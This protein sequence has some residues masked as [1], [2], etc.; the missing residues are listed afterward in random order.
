MQRHACNYLFDFEP[1]VGRIAFLETEHSFEW[2]DEASKTMEEMRSRTDATLMP[3]AEEIAAR[4]AKD[5]SSAAPADTASIEPFLASCI[6]AH[7]P[8]AGVALRLRQTLD[9]G[10]PATNAF[11]KMYE[12]CSAVEEVKAV[13]SRHG[14]T[15]TPLKAAFLAELPALFPIAV[16]YYLGNFFPAFLQHNLFDYCGTSL[17]DGLTDQFSLVG[18]NGSKWH[19]MDHTS[20]SDTRKLIA[21]LGGG[22]FDFVTGDI[23]KEVVNLWTKEREMFR[24]ELGQMVAALALLKDGGLA[25]LKMFTVR[26]YSTACLLRL[27]IGL[28]DKV[29]IIKPF[30]SRI[31]NEETYWILSGFKKP[32]FDPMLEPL[33][34]LMDTAT[35]VLS[36]VTLPGSGGRTPIPF[37]RGF[38][39]PAN[40]DQDFIERMRRIFFADLT[41]RMRCAEVGMAEFEQQYDLILS[42]ATSKEKIDPYA[43]QV[44]I[45]K[46]LSRL[47]D[48]H[49]EKWREMFPIS[50]LGSI[51]YRV[52]GIPRPSVT[53][54]GR[55]ETR[56]PSP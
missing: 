5:A 22:K 29:R 6:R 53:G 38:L 56:R 27:A 17:P 9:R 8:W 46:R 43:F 40:F 49:A 1:I 2:Y 24:E 19:F 11:A 48:E 37:Y 21:E 52:T 3:M 54:R 26:E 32:L 36:S 13:L 45:M 51:F 16:I 50:Q 28:F 39:S 25:V 33:L 12:I 44:E 15:L 41:R 14:T 20:S 18:E 23:G 35:A 30:T 47:M 7:D 10:L 55:R 31:Y 4:R 34:A 42:M